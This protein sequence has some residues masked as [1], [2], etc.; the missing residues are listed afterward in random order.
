[1]DGEFKTKKELINDVENESE[2][3]ENMTT[4]MNHLMHSDTMILVVALFLMIVVGL[5][6]RSLCMR[7]ASKNSRKKQLR[8]GLKQLG[9]NMNHVTRAMS[10]DLEVP[11]SP[12][13]VIRTYSNNGGKGKG[14]SPGC[15]RGEQIDSLRVMAFSNSFKEGVESTKVP[16]VVIEMNQHTKTER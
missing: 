11:N 13:S 5:V 9:E 3:D 16:S 4:K 14:E 15:V 10:N 8:G 7:L 1:M 6:F 2:G 12:F